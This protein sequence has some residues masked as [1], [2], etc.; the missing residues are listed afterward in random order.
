MN[1]AF[2]KQQQNKLI[3][4][5]KRNQMKNE[6]FRSWRIQRYEPCV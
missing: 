2:E 3:D 1:H 5:K 6:P 4:A